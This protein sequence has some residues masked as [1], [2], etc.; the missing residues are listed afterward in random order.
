[1]ARIEGEGAV[2]FTGCNFMWQ[3]DKHGKGEPAILCDG[4][5]LT[6]NGCYFN[7]DGKDVKVGSKTQEAILTAN[8]A[9]GG[10]QVENQIGEKCQMGFNSL[11]K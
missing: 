3:W 9:K 1:M 6:V 2:T 5:Q 8:R 7:Y 11:G 10:F 4:G